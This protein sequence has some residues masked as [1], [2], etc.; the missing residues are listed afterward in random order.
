MLF[1]DTKDMLDELL[2]ES[3][4]A[5][6]DKYFNCKE[7]HENYYVSKLYDE[8]EEVHEFLGDKCKSGDINYSTHEKVYKLIESEL[9]Y[10][11][12]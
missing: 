4:K 8:K 9:G 7:E 12:K 5:R 3:R 1:R 6:D 2:N 10:K 11:R